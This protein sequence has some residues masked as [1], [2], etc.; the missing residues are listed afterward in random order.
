MSKALL[1]RGARRVPRLQGPRVLEVL[2]SLQDVLQTAVRRLPR[3][4]LMHEL[5]HLLRLP[6]LHGLLSR[7]MW[8]PAF[9][10]Q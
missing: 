3:C 4:I 6:R 10:L 1:L 8:L 2:I 5:M 9:Y 7:R